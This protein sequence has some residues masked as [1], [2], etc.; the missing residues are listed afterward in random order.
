MQDAFAAGDLWIA[1]AWPTDWAA[2]HAKELKVAYMQP[3]EGA[4]SWIGMLMLGKGSKHP[5]TRTPSR[6]RGARF[7]SATGWKTTT[8]TATR[9]RAPGR[10]RRTC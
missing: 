7:R 3:K 5:S 2:M 1:Y 9:T 4:I 8:P 10:L 6:T